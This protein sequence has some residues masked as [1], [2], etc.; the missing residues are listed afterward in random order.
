MDAKRWWFKSP[1]ITGR[2]LLYFPLYSPPSLFLYIAFGVV[3]AGFLVHQPTTT[4]STY[5]GTEN[6]VGGLSWKCKTGISITETG[7]SCLDFIK[8]PIDETRISSWRGSVSVP[9]AS[10][11]LPVATSVQWWLSDSS[12]GARDRG[13]MRCDVGYLTCNVTQWR[14]HREISFF[15]VRGNLREARRRRRRKLW[16]GWMNGRFI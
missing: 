16:P 12:A 14:G 13:E 9:A 6:G 11:Y 5:T 8:P 15:C 4:V 2:A 10:F 3:L 7:A 1:L